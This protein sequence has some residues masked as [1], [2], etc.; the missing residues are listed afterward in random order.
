[1][2]GLGD[3]AGVVLYG[4]DG[5]T[6]PELGD[7]MRSSA[8]ASGVVGTVVQGPALDA[9]DHYCFALAGV[10]AVLVSSSGL[11]KTY[12]TPKDT[13]DAILPSVLETSA[14]LSW[15]ALSAL[16]MD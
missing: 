16:V 9:S 14:R 1:M 6:F 12:H 10:P 15:A 13:A 7:L 2:V 5:K 4:A 3:G 8:E 11:H